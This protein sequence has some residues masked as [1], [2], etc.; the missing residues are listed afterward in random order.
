MNSIGIFCASSNRMDALYYTETARLGSWIGS[1]GMTLVFGGVNSGIMEAVAQA[2]HKAGGK[3]TGVLPYVLMNSDRISDCL[4]STVWC[5]DLTDRKQQLIDSSD[6]LVVLPGG[7]GTL[8][9]VFTLMAAN[10]IG[11]S[12]KKVIFW[13]INGFWDELFQLFDALKAKNVINKPMHDLMLTANTFD[14]LVELLK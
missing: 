6:A 12:T 9:E 2:A 4:D 7:I 14:E 10:T 5:A 13:N 1:N 8:D 3:V 11:L